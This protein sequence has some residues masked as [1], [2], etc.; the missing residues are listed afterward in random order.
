MEYTASSVNVVRSTLDKSGVPV[1]PGS[2]CIINTS[3]F[4]IW[5]NQPWQRTLTWV[6]TSSLMT[7]VSCPRN[8]DTWNTSADSSIL[9]WIGRKVSHGASLGSHPFKPWMITG[10]VAICCFQ[11]P[12]FH[13]LSLSLSLPPPP[14]NSVLLSF[15][16]FPLSLPV[17]PFFF[18][19]SC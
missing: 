9:T 19:P 16:Y 1:W 11:D 8:R 10:K 4:T 2:R 13:S 6:T 14:F 7:S 18:H 15:L 12:L 5:M 17:L 3:D